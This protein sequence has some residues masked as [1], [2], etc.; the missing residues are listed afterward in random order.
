MVTEETIALHNNP[1]VNSVVKPNQMKKEDPWDV[2]INLNDAYEQNP[3]CNYIDCYFARAFGRPEQIGNVDKTIRVHPTTA[4]VER[5]QKII[6]EKIK[7]RYIVVHMRR[8]AWENK[9]VDVNTW[10][11]FFTLMNH[12]YPDVKIV[13]VGAQYDYRATDI[14]NGVD[15]VD[16]LSIGDICT[17]MSKAECFVGGDSGPY[18]IASASVVPIVALLSHMRPSQILPWRGG[19]FGHNVTVVQSDVPC[20]GC[21]SRQ[22]PPIRNLVCEAEEKWVCAK[23]FNPEAIFNAVKQYIK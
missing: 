22:T 11:N 13:S 18:H 5:V 21:Y 17:L 14:M 23:K 8:W 10:G 6:N 20:A 16:Q 3:L 7:S 12:H 15:L 9:N 1:D 4:E 19:V 2:Y